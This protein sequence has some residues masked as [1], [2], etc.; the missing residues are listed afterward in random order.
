MN[1]SHTLEF[2]AIHSSAKIETVVSVCTVIRTDS[3]EEVTLTK[4]NLTLPN[5]IL[6]DSTLSGLNLVQTMATINGWSA[7]LE[8]KEASEKKKTKANSENTHL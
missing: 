7:L 1:P 6:S 2:E 8:V 4:I 5:L 3:A